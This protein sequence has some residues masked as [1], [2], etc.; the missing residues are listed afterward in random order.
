MLTEYE[1]RGPAT[2]APEQYRLT[3]ELPGYPVGYITDA[4][5]RLLP[6]WKRLGIV[7]RVGGKGGR[8]RRAGARPVKKVEPSVD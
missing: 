1:D 2:A 4:R 5:N 7:E 3:R 8:P 6:S